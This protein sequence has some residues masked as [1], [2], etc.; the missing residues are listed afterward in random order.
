MFVSKKNTKKVTAGD[1][2]DTEVMEPE[3]DEDV[4]DDTPDAAEDVNVAPDATDLLF[5]AEDVAQLVAEVTGQ[6]VDVE[7]AEDGNSVEFTVG[8][9]VFTVTAEGDEEVLE[10][11]RKPLK[12][13]KQ[14]SA[15]TNR[16]PAGKTVRKLPGKK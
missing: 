2:L 6:P 15:S 9:D 13:K 8:E 10:A 16:K 11:V 5:E 12:K 14:V 1:D 4:V 3:M 7:K